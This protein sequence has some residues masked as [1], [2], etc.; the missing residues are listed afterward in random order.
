MKIRMKIL[1]PPYKK[2]R[3]NIMT[4]ILPVKNHKKTKSSREEGPE[5]KD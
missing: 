1:P 5:K 2:S 3:K 4:L